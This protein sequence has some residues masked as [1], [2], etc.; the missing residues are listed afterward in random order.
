MENVKFQPIAWKIV[1]LLY[2]KIVK[3]KKKSVKTLQF[4]L[5]SM[6]LW[7]VC[8]P[9]NPTVHTPSSFDSST[10]LKHHLVEKEAES[11]RYREETMKKMR[12][13]PSSFIL[14]TAARIL[15]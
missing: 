10:V 12:L 1:L 14:F 7:M 5:T 2:I 13:I 11:I 15:A 3:E 9:E 8:V 4:N 6:Y